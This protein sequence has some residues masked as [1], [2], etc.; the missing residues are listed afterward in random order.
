[1]AHL[2]KFEKAAYGRLYAHWTREK[3]AAGEYVTYKTERENG[4]HIHRER[5]N[6]NYCLGEVRSKAWAAERLKNVY[7][8]PNQKHPPYICDIVVTL[9]RSESLDRENVEKFMRAAYDSLIKQYGKYDNVVGAFVHLDE[10]QPHLHFAF[11]P[12]SPRKSRQKPEYTEKLSTRAYWSRKNALQI[13][14]QQLQRDISDALGHKVEIVNAATKARGGNKTVQQLKAETLE[15]QAHI[16]KYH[17]SKKELDTLAGERKTPLLS[18]EHYDLSVKQYARLRTLAKTSV[19]QSAE[20]ERMKAACE[21]LEHENEALK[22]ERRNYKSDVAEQYE[23]KLRDVENERDQ[24][25]QEA[26]PWFS[27][28]EQMREV[29]TTA[30]E[31]LC[32][33]YHAAC[34]SLCVTML[35]AFRRCRNAQ[36]VVDVAAPALR[37]LT[38]GTESVTDDYRE[39]VKQL[40]VA[41][42]R[43]SP[44]LKR[45]ASWRMPKPEEVDFSQPINNNAVKYFLQDAARCIDDLRAIPAAASRHRE[46]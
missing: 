32:R 6:Q 25:R 46:L 18:D 1:M 42:Q 40:D 14:H 39:Y 45:D 44:H 37:R 30:L 38:D 4:G 24:L 12:I 33:G 28:P 31:S 41:E 19:E 13:M 36:R 2:A 26:A 20:Y 17:G 34:N 7:Q 16:E 29:V 35:D 15:M 10:A 9:P 21:K 23:K 5:T 8:K 27:V 22:L 11:L 3:D 43:K